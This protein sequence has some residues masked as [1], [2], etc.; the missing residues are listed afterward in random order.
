MRDT[1]PYIFLGR[2]LRFQRHLPSSVP[3]RAGAWTGNSQEAAEFTGGIFDSGG[4]HPLV[5]LCA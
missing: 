4:T 5:F 2:D 3:L 1:L